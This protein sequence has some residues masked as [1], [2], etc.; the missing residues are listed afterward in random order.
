MLFFYSIVLEAPR[1][2]F[3][4]TEY[5]IENIDILSRNAT[6]SNVL[7]SGKAD[8]NHN[9]ESHKLETTEIAIRGLLVM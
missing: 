5:R 8:R 9:L 1:K 6:K 7:K 2:I 4:T 3:E